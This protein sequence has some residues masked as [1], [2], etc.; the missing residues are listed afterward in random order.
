[1]TVI[2]KQLRRIVV[3]RL[4]RPVCRA[5]LSDVYYTHTISILMYYSTASQNAFVTYLRV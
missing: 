4:M 2:G 5:L 3:I 1:M